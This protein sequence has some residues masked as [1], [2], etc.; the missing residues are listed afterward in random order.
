MNN[1]SADQLVSNLRNPLQRESVVK[2]LAL[3]GDAAVGPLVSFLLSSPGN[4]HE[5]GC[6]A[7]EALELIGGEE[8]LNGLFTALLTPIDLLV[9]SI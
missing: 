3:Q 4:E 5:P 8:A 1:K 6:C 7:V 2:E 9:P